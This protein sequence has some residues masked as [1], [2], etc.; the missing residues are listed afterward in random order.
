MKLSKG[1]RKL[2]PEDSI[3]NNMSSSTNQLILTSVLRGDGTAPQ[4]DVVALNTALVLWAAGIQDDLMIGITMAKN[5]L[6]NG[7]PWQKLQDLRVA[8][9]A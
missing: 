2:F 5:S 4:R 8:L 1:Q 3:D 9:D 7:E 6:E